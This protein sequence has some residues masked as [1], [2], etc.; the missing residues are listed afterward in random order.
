MKADRLFVIRI[1]AVLATGFLLGAGIPVS[2]DVKVGYKF[3]KDHQVTL[4]K[5]VE[6]GAAAVLAK[7]IAKQVQQVHARLTTKRKALQ[8]QNGPGNAPGYLANEVTGLIAGTRQDLDQAIQSVKPS[9]TEPLRAWVDDQFQQIQGQIPP[10]GSAA[11]LPGPSAPRTGVAL[12]SLRMGGLPV[13][14]KPKPKKPAPPKPQP[15]PPKAAPPPKPQT[16]PASTADRLL[17]QVEKVI[18][19]IF[20]LADHDNL[21]VNLW[22]GST[23]ERKARLVF[24]QT[25]HATF[26]FWPQGK[27]KDSPPAHTIIQLAGKK[28]HVLRGLYSYEADLGLE[29]GAVIQKIKYP[30]STA[31]VQS[32]RLDLVNGTGFFCC[33]FKEGYCHAVAN[34]KECRS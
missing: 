15:A 30:D 16:I 31:P 25:S 7:A 11:S 18:G 9:G 24:W 34:E 6:I 32:E 14:A 10:A 28:D 27:L 19:Q 8:I 26:S 22:V 2:G 5:G 1:T 3:G 23:Q 21:E 20:T 17:D 29:K 33:R 13:A 4:G 12:A